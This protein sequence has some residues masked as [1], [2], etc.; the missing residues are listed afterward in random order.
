M[1]VKAVESSFTCCNEASISANR[2]TLKCSTDCVRLCSKTEISRT[3]GRHRWRHTPTR[4]TDIFS[5]TAF[6]QSLPSF[7]SYF[8]MERV[9][10]FLSSVASSPP[11]EGASSSC[12]VSPR[13][14]LHFTLSCNIS[15]AS[16]SSLP[17]LHALLALPVSVFVDPYELEQR[18]QDEDGPLMRVWGETNL[19]LPVASPKLDQ[20]GSAILLTLENE[21]RN[22]FSVPFHARYLLPSGS[23]PKANVRTHETVELQYP[24]FFSSDGM[25]PFIPHSQSS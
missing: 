15:Y 10:P 7:P 4:E 3:A 16:S 13:Q 8:R 11:A 1:V 22:A 18:A 2:E 12:T 6:T 9:Q 23:E 5:T 19:E 24:T 25:C 17:H 14:S 20:R 21:F